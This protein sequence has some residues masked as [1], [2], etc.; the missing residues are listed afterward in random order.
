M[1]TQITRPFSAYGLGQPMKSIFPD[2]IVTTVAPTANDKGVIGQQWINTLTGDFYVLTNIIAG[3]PT[4]TTM[5]N[6]GGLFASIT[7]NPGDI[8]VTAGDIIVSLGDITATVGSITAGADLVAGN[9]ITAT[10]GNIV[11]TAG[12]VT[13][14]GDMIATGNITTVAGQVFGGTVVSNTTVVAG[15]TITA[16]TGITSTLGNI[17]ASAGGISATLGAVSAGTTVTAGTGVIATTGNVAALSGNLTASN[18]SV[19]VTGAAVGLSKSRAGGIIVTGDDLGAVVFTGHDGATFQIGA[20]IS[21]V[22][23]GTIG[24]GRVPAD[25]VFSTTPDAVSAD[26]DRVTIPADGGLVIS[27][28][29]TATTPPL[30]L[31]GPVNIYTGAGDPANGLAIQAGDMYIRT[32]PTGA[33]D[34][35]WIATGAGAWTFIAANA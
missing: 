14:G 10:A 6:A 7:V 34:R 1:A 27:A 33:N 2:P 32:N 8:N 29:T 5:S 24:A 22:S 30:V 35:L 20:A 18:V 21:V 17:V 13:A 25:I 16:G 28:P 3:V 26:I 4:W 23:T 15:T 19:G 31:P 9:D 12:N 11:A